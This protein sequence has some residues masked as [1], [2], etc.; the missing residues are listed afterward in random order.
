MSKQ[1]LW[2][3]VWGI[4][5]GYM[6]SAVVVYLREIYYPEGFAFP[7]VRI[8]DHILLTELLREA[9]TLLI[10]WTT[11]S[12]A[13]NKMQSRFAAFFLLFGL[14]DI[15]YYI[16]LKLLL[17]WPESLNT[18][19]ILFLIPAPWVGPVWAPVLVSIGFIYAGTTLLFQHQKNR[20]F[21][22][23][24]SFIL[25]ELTSVL[26]IIVS[27]MIPG[28]SLHEQHT[29]IHFPWAIFLTGFLMGIGIFLYTVYR[30]SQTDRS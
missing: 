15:F 26:L 21:H 13:Y 28:S 23:G 22:F 5:F 2:L 24:R 6:E 29:G 9:A 16:F 30:P 25:L 1:L 20:F 11:V 18:W 7:L 19:D 27:F 3:I 4:V 17:H 12:L 14:W 10:L 8:E